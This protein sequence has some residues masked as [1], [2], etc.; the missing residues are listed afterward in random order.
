MPRSLW[1]GGLVA[2]SWRR[3]LYVMYSGSSVFRW[4]TPWEQTWLERLLTVFLKR[5]LFVHLDMIRNG[6]D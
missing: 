2:L 1:K 4:G 6:T 3:E 5:S